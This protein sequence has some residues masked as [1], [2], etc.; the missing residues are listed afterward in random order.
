MLLIC[1]HSVQTLDRSPGIISYFRLA[2]LPFPCMA[3]IF[4]RGE[5]SYHDVPPSSYSQSE[6]LSW[7]KGQKTKLDELLGVISG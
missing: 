4:S 3:R 5:G 2:G 6:R 1:C 7:N